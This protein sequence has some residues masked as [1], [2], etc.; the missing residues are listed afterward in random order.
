MCEDRKDLFSLF[1]SVCWVASDVMKLFIRNLLANTS[2]DHNVQEVESALFLLYQLGETLSEEEMKSG[3]GLL[4]DLVA[5][6][7]SI[8]F[9]CN[10]HRIVALVYLETDFAFETV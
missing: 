9:S 8:R 4:A 6:L 5:M 1:R 2:S 7:L 10:S 3:S